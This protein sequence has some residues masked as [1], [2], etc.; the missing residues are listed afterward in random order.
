LLLV[1]L[2]VVVVGAGGTW[3]ARRARA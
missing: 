2:G 1:L 3:L